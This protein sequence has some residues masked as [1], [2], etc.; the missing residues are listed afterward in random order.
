MFLGHISGRSLVGY[1]VRTV[2]A[3]IVAIVIIA[4]LPIES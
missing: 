1:G 2:I 3:G 4:L